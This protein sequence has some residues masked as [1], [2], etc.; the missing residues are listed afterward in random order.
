[1]REG[2]FLIPAAHR[3]DLIT[4]LE[5]I[6]VDS[7]RSEPSNFEAHGGSVSVESHVG[8]GSK[9]SMFLPSLPMS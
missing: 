3:G 8:K 9:V 6:P 4:E 1:M 7:H 5:P 2:N